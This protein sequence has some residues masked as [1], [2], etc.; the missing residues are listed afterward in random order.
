MAKALKL[1]SI[2]HAHLDRDKIVFPNGGRVCFYAAPVLI[3]SRHLLD[4]VD[5]DHLEFDDLNFE[6]AVRFHTI[7]RTVEGRKVW[8]ISIT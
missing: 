5:W 7:C 1:S 6:M 3:S 2:V 4:G 8:R